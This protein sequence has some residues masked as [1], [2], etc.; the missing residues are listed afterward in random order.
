MKKLKDQYLRALMKK[1]LAKKSIL[2]RINNE[3]TKKIN[4]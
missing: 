2:K 3:E 4:V 1:V